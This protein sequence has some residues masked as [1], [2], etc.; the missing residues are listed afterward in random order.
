MM[1]AIKTLGLFAALLLLTVPAFSQP[2][3]L[4][5][6]DIH[7]GGFGGLELRLTQLNDQTGLLVGGGGAWV[8]NNSFYL[9]GAG[10]GLVNDVNTLGLGPDTT[11]IDFGYG[12]GLVGYMF[13][14]DNLVHVGVQTLVGAGGVGYR[15]HGDRES[16]SSVNDGD[17]FF[18][19][20]PG[21]VG[22][23]NI[24]K[25]IRLDLSAGYRFINGIET[26]GMSDRKLSG[27]SASMMI[28]FGSF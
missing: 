5:D 19:L 12:G 9:G 18:V 3:T 23:L 13:A 21:V 15:M 6:G 1:N 4:F 26:P 24:A 14:S 2:A 28:K 27:P 17:G 25:N 11:R 20:E 16:F 22:E 8:V 7:S 10:Y